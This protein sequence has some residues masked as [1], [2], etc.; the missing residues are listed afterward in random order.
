MD[1]KEEIFRIAREEM[2]REA[3]ELLSGKAQEI[4]GHVEEAKVKIQNKMSSKIGYIM[5]VALLVPILLLIFVS[6]KYATTALEDTYKNYA[7]NLAE[8]AA[9]GVN[10]ADALEVTIDSRFE[11][12]LV[13]TDYAGLIGGI[14]IDGVEGSYAYMV[15]PDGTMLY[16]KDPE[17]IGQPVENAAVKGIVEKLKAG[18]KVENGAVVY[19][20]KGANKLAGYAFS[21]SGDI[22]VVTADYATMMAPVTT[23]KTQ[24]SVIGIAMLVIFGVI[25]VVASNAMIRAL[26][27]IVPSIQNTANLVFTTDEQAAKLAR[28]K[29]EIGVIARE[30][31]KMQY[32]LREIVGNMSNATANIDMNV[33]CLNDISNRV[34]ANCAE[35]FQISEDLAAGMEETSA[36]T[37][38]ITE[39]VS[40]MQS[41][42]QEIEQMALD[43]AAVSNEVMLRANKLRSSTEE[44]THN[45]MEIYTS[46]RERSGVAIEAADAVNKINELTETV[47]EISSQTSLLAL[48]ASIEAA[49]AGE[50]GRGF[51]VVAS[52]ISK[53]AEE[54]TDA[55]NDI[56]TIV[57]EVNVAVGNMTDCLKEAIDFLEHTVLK[58]Y[59]NFGNVSVQYQKDADEF[60]NSMANI[61]NGVEALNETMNVIMD[62]IS[63]IN[64]T[65][66]EAAD[67][68]TNFAG[69]TSDMVGETEETAEMVAECK[70]YVAELND[71]VNQFTLA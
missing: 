31:D 55:V 1:E 23:L 66:G 8:E 33:D 38:L 49:R 41:G 68:V 71:I 37:V 24:L 22:V 42:A 29:D 54:T 58:D 67:G 28:R 19:E 59:D 32:N 53:L 17:K 40:T 6:T 64:H 63:E 20:Y 56:N 52:E 26:E 57:A 13:Q 50:A 36:S 15:S 62:S 60:K 70:G 47:M 45:T 27:R 18:E 9:Q 3:A 30:I 21:D 10:Y 12:D 35:N 39:N 46:V 11:M 69:R 65:M 4:K 43:G 25:G 51:A 44:A 61:K 2:E 7:K 34:K 14:T 48:N 5:V 16:H